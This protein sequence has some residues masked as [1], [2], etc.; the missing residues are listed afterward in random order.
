MMRKGQN[1][2]FLGMAAYQPQ[3][4]GI[5]TMI[6]APSLD[7]Y[8]ENV[9][10]IFK[11]QLA[12]IYETTHIDFDLL[13]LDN[14]SCEAVKKE[15]QALFQEGWIDWLISSPHNL[16]RTGG[17]NIIY[18]A[19]QNELVCYTDSD[20]LFRP[21]WLEAS[22]GIMDA[23]PKPGMIAAQPM[24]FD[25]MDGQATA[26]L[27]LKGDPKFEFTTVKPDSNALEDY[28]LGLGAGPEKRAKLQDIPH[29]VVVNKENNQ[30]AI[31][32]ATHMQFLT[33]REVIKSITPLPASTALSGKESEQL[34]W[35]IDEGGY[36]HLSTQKAF[37][38][39]MGNVVDDRLRIEVSQF[40][41]KY[42]FIS[43]VKGS[44]SAVVKSENEQKEKFLVRFLGKLARKSYF[45]RFFRR[46]Y[47]L[48]FR[49]LAQ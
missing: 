42:P 13:V 9:L 2:A 32:G 6:F 31:I 45:K 27:A 10:E 17:M 25:V 19:L 24:F 23:F 11:Y 34:D 22:L 7:G 40:S 26:H 39:H 35:R 28:C 43:G 33:T 47:N 38:Y 48:M 5:G 8:F 46:V 29:T 41:S 3:K 4:L 36:L 1:P 15:L 16:G 49:V 18:G 21:G 37:V 14:G 20:V 44:A 12:S 30:Q